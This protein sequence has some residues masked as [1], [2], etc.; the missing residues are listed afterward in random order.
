M[1]KSVKTW[2]KITSKQGLTKIMG[3]EI[4]EKDEPFLKQIFW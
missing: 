3:H 2:V 4:K 1:R